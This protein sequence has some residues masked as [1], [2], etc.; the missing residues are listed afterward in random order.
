MNTQ[1]YLSG[2]YAGTH[3]VK[4][5]CQ[6]W[7][8][9]E[10]QALMILLHGAG[11]HSGVYSDIG[12]ECL[13]RHIG[14]IAPD[15]RGFGKSD[16]VRGH[17][18]RFQEY[19]DDMTALIGRVRKRFPAVPLFLLGHSFGGLIAIRFA[20]VYPDMVKGVILSS[21]A[22]GMRI[23][24]PYPLKKAAELISWIAPSLPVDPFK[25]KRLQS[26]LLADPSDIDRDP[27]FT[28]QYTPRWFHEF[29]QNGARALS[30]AAKCSSPLLCL[31]GQL[32]P[33]T[34]LRVVEKFFQ[35]AGSADRAYVVFSEGRHRPLHEHYREEALRNIFQWITTRL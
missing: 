33:L 22:L 30:E 20:Q 11:E 25:W 16:G 26:V 32:D 28:T 13:R 24:L 14:L 2:Y 5:Y 3:G 19:L 27:L 35:S 23:R 6:E 10:L 21:P 7:L 9:R 18:Q 34:D 4:L 29:L 31:C 17:I 1:C 12:E 15:L 8:P